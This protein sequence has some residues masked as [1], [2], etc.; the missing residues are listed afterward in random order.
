M[1]LLSAPPIN[2]RFIQQ[3]CEDHLIQNSSTLRCLDPHSPDPQIEI[4]GEKERDDLS[5][6]HKQFHRLILICTITA[7]V[8]ALH[9]NKK[10]REVRAF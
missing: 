6:V 8:I 4:I 3:I 1:C 5:D 2:F 7:N 9:F 10:K